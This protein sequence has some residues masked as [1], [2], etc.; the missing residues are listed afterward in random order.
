M[1]N[2]SKALI[3]A[4]GILIAV[5][6]M[7]I[8]VYVFATFGGSSKDIQEQLNSRNLAEF[9]NN[10]TKFQGSK[11]ITIHD[12][13]SLANFA[14]QYNEDMGLNYMDKSYINVCIGK[15]NLSND[16]T[17]DIELLK[18][19]STNGEE[20][21]YYKCQKIEYDDDA[22]RVNEILFTENKKVGTWKKEY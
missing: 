22:K 16:T 20:I 12:I 6:I 3:M 8:G 17:Q 10:F 4:G 19:K 13:I 5:I 9:N 14:R 21:K 18:S 11:E 7:T 1:E 15:T 2:A